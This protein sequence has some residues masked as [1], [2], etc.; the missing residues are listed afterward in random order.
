MAS[1][2]AW[3]GQ[4]GYDYAFHG[5][6]I[7]TPIDPSLRE[8]LKHRLPVLADLAR[9]YA[10]R[11]ALENYDRVVWFDADTLLFAPEHLSIDIDDS[12]ALGEETWIEEDENGR[13][14]PRRNLHNALLVIRRGDPVLP[15]LIRCTERILTRIDPDKV[16][17]QIVGPKLLGAL[18]PMADF[19]VLPTV[20]ALSPL[21]IRDIAAGR[22]NALTL[23]K[24]RSPLPLAGANLCASLVG[25]DAAS[26][27]VEA[28]IERM[29][30]ALA[31]D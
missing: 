21:V 18:N 24:R 27:P 29:A 22:G 9:L 19:A 17:P 25:L 7:F 26:V 13:L 12:F 3:A 28:A 31:A 8:K 4:S 14:K 2:R 11:T 23:F 1:V 15:F 6:E 10:A 30:D 16:A 5:D 20:G